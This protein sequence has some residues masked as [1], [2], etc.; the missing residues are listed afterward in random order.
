MLPVFVS[1]SV[2]GRVWR[3]D[4]NNGSGCDKGDVMHAVCYSVHVGSRVARS[5]EGAHGSWQFHVTVPRNH[6]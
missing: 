6:T 3:M 1:K 2:S 4:Y 5:E